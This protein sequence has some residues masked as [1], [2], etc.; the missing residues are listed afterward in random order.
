[1]TLGDG[2]I[3]G[4]LAFNIDS[5]LSEVNFLGAVSQ[6][7]MGAFAYCT[8]LKSLE[9]KAG[10][11]SIDN[12]AFQ[13]CSALESVIIPEG[14]VTI[15]NNAFE[16]CTSLTKVT[17]PESVMT[18]G[19]RAFYEC[20]AMTDMY[21]CCTTPPALDKH[22]FANKSFR[23]TTVHVPTGCK[24]AYTS[25]PNWSGFSSIVDDITSDIPSVI[26][27]TKPDVIYDMQGHRVDHLRS[28]INIIRQ[29]DGTTRKVI[30]K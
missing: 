23:Q 20:S 15:D 18:I 29:S 13:G 2:V 11:T 22:A 5:S 4:E 21:V 26:T 10:T 7:D 12:N 1:V 24:G 3:V 8:A 16:E 14:V 9:L 27:D 28:G 25:A 30:V 17:I 19:F 6:F